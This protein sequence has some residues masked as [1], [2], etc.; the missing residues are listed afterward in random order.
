LRN[1]QTALSATITAIVIGLLVANIAS[2]ARAA[3]IQHAKQAQI[4]ALEASVGADDTA[5]QLEAYRQ[6]YTETYNQMVAL[7]TQMQQRDAGY[8]ALLS[9]SQGQ[10]AQLEAANA[11]LEAR[12]AAAYQAMQQA[13]G[14]LAAMGISQ[15]VAVNAPAQNV[16]APDAGAPGAAAA[17]KTAAKTTAP[18]TAPRTATP[19]PARTVAPANAPTPAP[20]ATPK[21]YCWYDADGKWV[22][23]DHPKGQ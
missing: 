17:P 6:R 12:L 20:Q 3:E 13:Q 7:Y 9:Q 21:M 8:G 22:C 10:G 23:E 4:A 2:A 14:Q 19:T 16:A 15:P 11:S 1:L 5:L 18:T